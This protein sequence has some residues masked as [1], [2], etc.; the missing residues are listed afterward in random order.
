[1]EETN[2]KRETYR[3][4][5]VSEAADMNDN[6]DVVCNDS[7][8]DLLMDAVRTMTSIGPYHKNIT[9]KHEITYETDM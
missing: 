4:Q 5:D 9:S 6:H 3:N 7:G 1:M 2:H 8:I